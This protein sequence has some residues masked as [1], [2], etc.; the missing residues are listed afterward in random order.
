VLTTETIENIPAGWR[1]RETYIVTG[2]NE[3]EEVFELAEPGKTFELYSRSRLTR[4][5]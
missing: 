4:V 3:L 5:P 2:S 1:A